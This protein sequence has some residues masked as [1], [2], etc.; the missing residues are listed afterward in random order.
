MENQALLEEPTV[1]DDAAEPSAG[2]GGGP[3]RRF[4][5][6]MIGDWML[7]RIETVWPGRPSAHWLGL[8]A[9]FQASNDYLCICNDRAVLLAERKLHPMAAAPMVYVVFCWSRDTEPG[10]WLADKKG[11]PVFDLYNACRRWLT[12]MGGERMI[13]GLCDD[14]RGD[15]I[16]KLW[17]GWRGTEGV[18]VIDV[19]PYR[20]M[21][22]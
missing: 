15:R 12:E 10:N 6:D 3:I 13:C 5:V 2:L 4:T 21:R 20:K 1:A 9:G 17:L 22:P 8:F 19:K 7:E 16:A 14:L 11:Q 18:P